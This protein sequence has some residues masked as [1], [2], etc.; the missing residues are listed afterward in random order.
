LPENGQSGCLL[1]RLYQQN[2]D[3]R[4]PSLR[5]IHLFAFVVLFSVHHVFISNKKCIDVNGSMQKMATASSDTATSSNIGLQHLSQIPPPIVDT[6][7]GKR[8][9][10][11]HIPLPLFVGHIQ[12]NETWLSTVLRESLSGVHLLVTSARAWVAATN[13]VRKKSPYP[14]ISKALD[15]AKAA[16]GETKEV[17]W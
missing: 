15:L 13:T 14:W 2:G 12:E 10:S 17:G 7:L 4:T 16:R 5:S 6:S 11:N 8:A 1:L 3:A 9:K